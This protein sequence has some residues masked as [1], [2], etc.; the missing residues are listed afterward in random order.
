M[1]FNA[2]VI[3]SFLVLLLMLRRLIGIMPSLLACMIRW[4]ENI[5]LEDSVK[6]S[7]DRDYLALAM[8]VPFCLLAFRYRLYSPGFVEPMS[9]NAVLGLYFA[10]FLAYLVVRIMVTMTFR[11]HKMPKKIFGTAVKTSYSFFIICTLVLLATVAVMSVADASDVHIRNAMLWISALIYMLFLIR[12]V[13]IFSTSCSVFAAFLYLC[14]LEMI[15]TGIL[16]VSAM[17][18]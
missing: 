16:V 5:N 15:P 8:I 7:R 9:D 3:F 17:I 14:A 10:I 11:P 12:K 2:L 4:K 13:Q 1:L 6:L 18:F